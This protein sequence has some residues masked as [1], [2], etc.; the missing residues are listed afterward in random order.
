MLLEILKTYVEVL[1]DF[2]Y[3]KGLKCVAC[4]KS[5]D[6][7][8]ANSICPEC[9]H[10]LYQI[11][12]AGCSHCGR[13]LGHATLVQYCR[14]CIKE[15]KAFDR[16]VSL[17]IYNERSRMMVHQLKFYEKRYL[18]ESMACLM[19]SL[20]MDLS[21]V[22]E[23]DYII[24]V[25]MHK[26]KEKKRGYNQVDL[27]VKYMCKQTGISSKLGVLEK[28]RNTESQNQL[29][30]TERRRNVEGAFYVQNVDE[31]LER[32]ILLID[33]VYTTGH[34]VSACSEV[35]KAAGAHKVYV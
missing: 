10:E 5:S 9:N 8:D 19:S 14:D 28:I 12:D 26:S 3:P 13:W 2:I 32:N 33:D 22:G 31:I 4:S 18:S 27:L 24:P 29:N 30:R 6:L 7:L 16:C 20:L 15:Y 21:F 11:G 23:I 25:P 17:V 1:K 35:L 34:T